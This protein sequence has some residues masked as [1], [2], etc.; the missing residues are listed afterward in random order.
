MR[1]LVFNAGSSSLKFDLMDVSASG[2]P[3]PVKA[4]SFV[5]AAEG[6]GEFELR[7][8]AATK[9]PSV[10]VRSLA[11]AAH[12]VLDW[13]S[14]VQEQGSDLLAGVAASVHRIV[15]GGDVFRAT[16]RLEAAQLAS[17]AE[18]SVL[19]P[20]H[21]PPALSVIDAVRAKLGAQVPLIGVFD[22]AYYAQLPEAAYCY[23]L[24]AR[25]R[26]EFGVRRY[27]FHGIAHR[28]LSQAAR[29][30]LQGQRD[31]A[32]IISLQL[33]RGC[34]VTATLDGRAIATSMGFTPLA[35]LVMGTRSGDID[36]G[37]L[38]YVMER[39]GMSAAQVS[40]DLNEASGL[41]G[42][43]GTADMRELLARE[44]TA[45]PHAV[46]AV[47]IFCRCARHYLGAY[48]AELGGADVIVFGGG[49]GENTPSVRQRILG[50]LEWAGI[51]VDARA[52]AAAV[53]I[54]ADIAAA[55]SRVAIQVIPVDEASVIASEAA[56]LLGAQNEA[57]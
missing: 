32:R 41:L 6:S 23:A 29:A 50:G 36:P 21:N 33:G 38:L 14:N 18:L 52:N 34:S 5:A 24:P 39:K 22:T 43:A 8:A 13:F 20:L 19:A 31:T 7:T 49:I 10:P 47:E 54:A 44:Q 37:A 45:D 12:F 25:W 46:L 4:G 1:L 9:L 55:S 40:C 35:G 2:A 51:Q 57:Q 42:L 30:R 11:E 3:R 53:G 28:S 26:E 56:A 15:H 17:L 27:G 16:T 48:L